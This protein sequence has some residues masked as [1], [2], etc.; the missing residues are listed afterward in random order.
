MNMNEYKRMIDKALSQRTPSLLEQLIEATDSNQKKSLFK[1]HSKAWV[2]IVLQAQLVN[3]LAA[4]DLAWALNPLSGTGARDMDEL[5]VN[6]HLFDQV[7]LLYN[8]ISDLDLYR[9]MNGM[10]D[11]SQFNEYDIN[12][13]F[14][15]LNQA[16][17]IDP[18]LSLIL[19]NLRA[20]MP[21]K[22]NRDVSNKAKKVK[23]A[24]NGKVSKKTG[25]ILRLQSSLFQGGRK[26]AEQRSKR[27]PAGKP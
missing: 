13:Y 22:E 9:K 7:E 12:Q 6:E 4:E 1:Q 18:A 16:H 17:S 19:A 8:E 26:K 11:V 21:E 14:A 27:M 3:P 25:L 10:I 23:K 5:V 15:A 24:C 20:R 2:E